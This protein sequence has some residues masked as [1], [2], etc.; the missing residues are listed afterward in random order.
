M[1][2]ISIIRHEKFLH[3]EAKIYALISYQVVAKITN[4]GKTLN[5]HNDWD[6]V[7][8]VVRYEIRSNKERLPK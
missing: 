5:P 4:Y 1:S 2:M 3:L 6:I 8:V 7:L